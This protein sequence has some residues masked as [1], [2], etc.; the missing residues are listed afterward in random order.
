MAVKQ[1]VLAQFALQALRANKLRSFLTVLGII[2]GVAAVIIML[3]IG[4]GAQQRVLAQISSLGSN[5]LMVFPGA[6]GQFV[7]GSGGMVNTLTLGD[8]RA[9]EQ[10][11]GVARVAPLVRSNVLVTYQNKTWT[12]GVQGTTPEMVD[13]SSLQLAAGRFFSEAE[14]KSL[15]PVA[16][17]GQTVYQNLFPYG[18]EAVGS[19]IRLRGETFRVVGVL[20]SLGASSGGQDRDDVVYV[21]VTTAQ[22]RLLGLADQSV[23]LVQVQVAEKDQMTAVQE[24]ITSLLRK[25][26]RLGPRQASDF[27]I[28]NIAQVQSTAESVTG[29]LTLF[30][31]SVAAISLLVGGIGVMNI[32][33]VSVT[34]RT[35]EIGVRMAVG[36]SRRDILH[37]FLLEAVLLSLAGCFFGILVGFAGARIF[38]ALA[39]WAAPVSLF[40]VLLAVGFSLAIGIFFGYYPARRAAGLNPAE[41]LGYE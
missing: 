1:H 26:H 30:L 27:N 21:P 15:A 12:T 25:R 19:R 28:R 34:E 33:L 18:G 6:A 37:Q 41:A 22:I 31:A 23:Q 36:A 8:A 7:R 32:M 35:R 5:L 16:V 29:M 2:I 38:A 20:Q 9:I 3:A 40:S 13:I 4:R 14:V 10:L 24:D 17:L 39:G 11:P